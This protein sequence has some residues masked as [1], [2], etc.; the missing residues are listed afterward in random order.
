MR[1]DLQAEG[2]RFDPDILHILSTT[3]DG[4][5]PVVHQAVRTGSTMGE[6][7]TDSWIDVSCPSTT[8]R[9]ELGEDGTFMC[10]CGNAVKVHMQTLL[11]RDGDS[12]ILFD[13]DGC[14]K[15]HRLRHQAG[16]WVVTHVQDRRRA[17]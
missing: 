4:C 2:H 1:A 11:K 12:N 14:R 15:G 10:C 8:H 3:Q 9:A 6:G 16:Q 17:K 7:E 13:D 5:S